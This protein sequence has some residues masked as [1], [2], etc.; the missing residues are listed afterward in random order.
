MELSDTFKLIKISTTRYYTCG[1]HL[2]IAEYNQKCSIEIAGYVTNVAE[3][4][5]KSSW[6]L[7]RFFFCNG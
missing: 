2:S 7:Q 5:E 6:L 1:D 4:S 3:L